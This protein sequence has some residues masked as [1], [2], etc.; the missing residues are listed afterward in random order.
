MPRSVV[1]I[2]NPPVG[3]RDVTSVERAR[4]YARDGR[5]VFIEPLVIRFLETALQSAIVQASEDRARLQGIGSRQAEGYDRTSR[6]FVTDLRGIP[7]INPDKMIRQEKSSRAWSF[8][9]GV[10]H[11]RRK[12]HDAKDV[13][14]IRKGNQ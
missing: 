14:R 1:R 6:S 10:D 12:D 13:A 3:F 7:I 2:E 9:A 5:A 8:S 4:R 11:R